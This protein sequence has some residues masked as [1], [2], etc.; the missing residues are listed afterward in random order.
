M[1]RLLDYQFDNF[2]TD[3]NGNRVIVNAGTLGSANDAIMHTG[4]GLEFDGTDDYINTGLMVDSTYRTL[5]GIAEYYVLGGLR[6]IA[7]GGN[8]AASHRFGIGSYGSNAYWGYANHYSGAGALVENKKYIHVMTRRDDGNMYGFLNGTNVKTAATD[9]LGTETDPD[10]A[11]AIGAKKPGSPLQFMDGKIYLVAIL[12]VGMTDNDVTYFQDHQEEFINMVLTGT[13]NPNYSFTPS[14]IIHCWTLDEGTG[15]TI[16]DIVTGD[17]S[18]MTNFPTDDTQWTN[19]DEES[20]CHQKERYK[21]DAHGN[22]SALADT[23]TVR[24]D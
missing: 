20:V 22:P 12:D 7:F 8:D 19:A 9:L 3:A 23:N 5:I 18:A 16:Y 24:F 17:S 6:R 21:K 1:A 2:S 14:N 10:Y 15:N 11:L 13:S 4:Q